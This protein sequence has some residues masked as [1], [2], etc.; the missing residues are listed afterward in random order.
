MEKKVN[1][2][3]KLAYQLSLFTIFY[4]LIE[5]LV[6]IMLGYKDETLTLFGF[7]VDSFIEVLSGIGI[8]I[9]LL[10]IKQNPEGPKSSFEIKALKTTG[11]AF[12]LLSAG[13]AIGI[14]SNILNH[15]KPETTLWG[16]I[17]SLVSIAVMVWLMI[18]KKKTGK[19]LNSEPIIADA[20]CTKVCVYMSI[21][22]LL[23]SLIYESTGFAY[24]DLLGA[25][26]LIYF[27]ITEGKE[28]FEKA[29]GKVDNCCN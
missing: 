7:G 16:I 1:E 27:S 8:Y 25:G 20:N 9:M 26:G 4:N 24:A 28:A 11:L 22:L 18:V 5:G 15:H 12:Y 19:Q 29:K 17:I 10:R 23:S 21:V 6:S 14:I 3:Y 13:L 2:L